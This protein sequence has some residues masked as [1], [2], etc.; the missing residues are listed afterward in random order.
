VK[1]S[2]GLIALLIVCAPHP[3]LAQPRTH[4]LSPR[5]L[6]LISLGEAYLASGDRGS[7]IGYF[8]EALVADPLAA[9]AYEALGE[10]YRARGSFEDARAVYETGLGR[11]PDHAGL[12]IGLARSLDAQGRAI[13]AAQAL[14]S[15]LARDPHHVEGLSLRGE[16]ARRRGAWTEA[17]GAYRALLSIDGLDEAARA[18]ARRYEAALRLLAEPIDPVSAPRVCSGSPVRR[19][20]GRCP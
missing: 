14:R 17:L 6:R 3:A 11:M 4:E 16:L 20:L 2:L 9:R 7:A 8:R 1:T 12:W 13:E 15:L 18:D 19:A 5:V 10:A